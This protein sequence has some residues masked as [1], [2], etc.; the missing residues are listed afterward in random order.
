MNNALYGNT[1]ENLGNGFDVILRGSK[2]DYLKWT[3][4]P[5][6]MSQI[7]FDNNLVLIRNTKVILKL[8]KQ[9]YVGLCVLHLS[10]VLMYEFHYY[11]IQNKSGNNS[12]LSERSIC[13]SSRCLEDVFKTYLEDVFN[14]TSA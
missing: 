10:I 13:W 8:N 4:S 1:M 5:T 9:P 12:R 6:Y 3:S 11:C 14:T 7:I 2:K